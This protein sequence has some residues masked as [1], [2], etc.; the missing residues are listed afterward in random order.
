MVK[1]FCEVEIHFVS[2]M[3]NYEKITENYEKEEEYF[4]GVI[5]E[6]YTKLKKE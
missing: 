3:K 2:G 4:E 1:D 5:N 6:N